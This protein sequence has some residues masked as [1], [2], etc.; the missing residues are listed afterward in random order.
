MNELTYEI[1]KKRFNMED[2]EIKHCLRGFEDIGRVS[3]FESR[4]LLLEVRGLLTDIVVEDNSDLYGLPIFMCRNAEFEFALNVPDALSFSD[5]QKTRYFERIL[6]C[7]RYT[8]IRDKVLPSLEKLCGREVAAEII[9]N[10]YISSYTTVPTDAIFDICSFLSG[11]PD[12][13]GVLSD[14]VSKNWYNVFSIYSDPISAVQ[15]IESMFRKEFVIDIITDS[16]DWLR[17]GYLNH[18]PQFIQQLYDSWKNEVI[19]VAKEKFAAY[20]V[21]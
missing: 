4:L 20:L 15:L 1:L 16:V 2:N 3:E 5:E 17:I 7:S 12:P 21:Q 11:Y 13:S 19:D 9:Q 10:L 14:F 8:D 6:Y 18:E